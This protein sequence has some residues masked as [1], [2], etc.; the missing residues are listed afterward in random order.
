VP[1]TPRSADTPSRETPCPGHAPLS[2]LRADRPVR[3]PRC[4]EPRRTQRA[5]WFTQL[6]TLGWP[7]RF[8][9]VQ[10]PNVPLIAAFTAGQSSRLVNGAAH[11]YLVSAAYLTMTIWAYEELVHGVNWVRRLLGLTYA[12]V[13]ILRVAHALRT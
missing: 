5:R 2:A 4:P 9:I 3:T 1:T 13:M 7:Q 10:F 6:T 12:I 11:P 8:L